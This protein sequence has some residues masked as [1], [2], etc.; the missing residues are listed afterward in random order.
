[1]L[2]VIHDQTFPF[3]SG[4]AI[5]ICLGDIMANETTHTLRQYKIWHLAIIHHKKMIGEIK[6]M[7]RDPCHLILGQLSFQ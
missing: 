7:V 6:H 2:L 4:I 1:M 5:I 3:F